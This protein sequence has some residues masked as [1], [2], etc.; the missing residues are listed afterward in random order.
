VAAPATASR[1]STPRPRPFE[2][3]KVADFA[4]VGVGPLVAKALADHGATVVHVESTTRLDTLRNGAPFCEGVEGLNRSQFFANF[5]SSK[6]G[7]SLN[8]AQPRGQEVARQLID[9]ADIV[10]ESFT[11]GTM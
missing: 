2:G 11:P 7:L 4:W 10:V 1:T 8:I 6:L 5:N 3:L 9:W